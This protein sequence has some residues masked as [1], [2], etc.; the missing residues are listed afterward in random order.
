MGK[1]KAVRSVTRGFCAGGRGPRKGR[2]LIFEGLCLRC[3]VI[4]EQL[5]DFSISI[6]NIWGPFPFYIQDYYLESGWKVE[7]LE[8]GDPNVD[9]K[10]R[11]Y[12]DF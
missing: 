9:L 3:K 11:D 6:S 8:F 1:T 5:H 4:R 10:L 7:A 2:W 12:M